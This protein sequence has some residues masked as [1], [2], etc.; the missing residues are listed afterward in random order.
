MSKQTNKRNSDKSKT[1]LWRKIVNIFLL[2]LLA[3]VVTRFVY[4]AENVWAAI[5]GEQI[6]TET[7]V[8]LIEESRYNEGYEAGNSAAATTSQ[9]IDDLREQLDDALEQLEG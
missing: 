1:P 4:N 8:E 6:Y 5:K 2:I 3:L 9:I 7:Q